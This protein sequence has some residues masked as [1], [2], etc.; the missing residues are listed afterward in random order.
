M[1]FLRRPSRIEFRAE[2]LYRHP[3]HEL[4]ESETS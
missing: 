4:E 1:D 3:Q 2:R